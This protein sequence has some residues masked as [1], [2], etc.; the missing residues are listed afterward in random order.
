[1]KKVNFD[2]FKRIHASEELIGKALAIPEN[3]DKKPTS[4]P[5]YRN[6]RVVATAASVVLV[7]TLG[8]SLYF[9]FGN[10]SSIAVAPRVPQTASEIATNPPTD[11]D[12]EPVTDGMTEAPDDP[13][14]TATDAYRASEGSTQPSATPLPT[15]D[16]APVLP[17]GT[18]AAAPTLPAST[19]GATV[20]PAPTQKATAKPASPTH[21]PTTVPSEPPI[22]PQTDDPW[23]HDP[24]NPP[25]P[26]E[27]P[28]TEPEYDP[29]CRLSVRLSA[30]YKGSFER[31]YCRIYDRTAKTVL[32]DPD[33][34][35]A[36]HQADVIVDDNDVIFIYVPSEHGID[37]P[38]GSYAVAFHNENGVNLYTYY[39]EVN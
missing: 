26:W 32:G 2:S 15:G 39:V 10:K 11:A 25:D 12:G 24:T 7:A 3:A 19:Q 36:S 31:V 18:Q 35:A 34:Y 14:T 20:K 30:K 5:W 33:R 6:V 29:V 16:P 1:M 37:M 13:K 4:L 38:P 21:A 22:A 8:I 28:V 17:D 9:L 23:N 27:H